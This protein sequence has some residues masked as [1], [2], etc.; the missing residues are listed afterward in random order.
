MPSATGDLI[1]FA[2]QAGIKLIQTGRKVY[3]EATIGGEVEVPLP[4]AFSGMNTPL[5]KGV[6]Y[7]LSLKTGDAEKKRR[8]KDRYHQPLTDLD[9]ADATVKAAAEWQIVQ[10]Y[11]K[12]VSAG[13]VPQIH[14]G[15][16]ELASIAVLKQWEHGRSPFPSAVQRVA[17][18]L[19]EIAIEYFVHVPGALNAQSKRGRAL[20]SFLAGLD[21]VQFSDARWDSLVIALFT[22]ALDTLNENPAI[23]SD[24]EDDQSLIRAIVGGVAADVGEQLGAAEFGDLDAE[25]RVKRFG[26]LVLR[27]LL[28]NAGTAVI[29]DPSILGL[30]DARGKAMVQSVGS[31][32]L[33][34]LL[35]DDTSLGEGLRR[36]ASTDGLDKLMRAA[37]RAAVEHPDLFATG[38]Q[39]IDVWLTDVLRDLDDRHGEG[40]TVF[41]PELFAEVAFSAMSY[42]MRDLPALLKP[43]GSTSSAVL[44]DLARLVF[45]K[46]NE[47]GP[48][49]KPKWQGLQLSRSDVKDLF[50]GL[51]ASLAAHT[52]WFSRKKELAA[53]LKAATTV[54]PQVI[55]VLAG[56]GDGSLK[57]MLRDG[58]LTPVLAA[59]LASGVID[60][61]DAADVAKIAEGVT[62]VMDAILTG[63]IN[64]AARL[65][66]EDVLLDLLSAVAASGTA[67]KLFGGVAEDVDAAVTRL[68]PIIDEL[69]RGAILTVT[70]MSKRLKAA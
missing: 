28:V 20:K 62:A 26:Q 8:F 18:T 70:D 32:F 44:V 58:K 59:V 56:L 29:E 22:T 50:D 3:V 24:E 63:G 1:V 15:S 60:P 43:K 52:T 7:A 27:G 31:A 69:R 34:L 41:D 2:V 40:E 46:L 54:L 37:L 16:A 25:S 66:D 64:G 10:E 38:N 9:N 39:T 14:R 30:T 51:F 33:S 65:L 68:M 11:L 23:F 12:D 35:D 36:I 57:A 4:P 21:A 49:G 19:V 42:A 67:K 17:G 6:E 13:L 5:N 48:E 55:D 45:D 47:T 53:A 61:R